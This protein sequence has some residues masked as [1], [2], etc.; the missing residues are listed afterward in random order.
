MKTVRTRMLKGWQVRLLDAAESAMKTAYCPYSS[1]PVGAALLTSGGKIITGSNVENAA[2]GS[3]ICAERVALVRA[4]AMGDRK[5]KAIAVVTGVVAGRDAPA[6]PCGA[7]RQMLYEF[8]HRAGADIEVIAATTTRKKVLLTSI[9]E[10]LP[11]PFGPDLVYG[12]TNTLRYSPAPRDAS[13]YH[14]RKGLC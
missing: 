5:F 7:C 6:A 10:L 3:T 14:F 12:F 11:L 13:P 9:D 1:F 2:F 8:R 4:N